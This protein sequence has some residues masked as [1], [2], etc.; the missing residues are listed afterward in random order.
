MNEAVHA[1]PP[2][3][4]APASVAAGTSTR[5]IARAAVRTR[6][7]E[8]AFELFRREGFDRVT[9]KEVSA[10]AGVSR[11]T[12]LRYFDSKEDAI[13]SAFE[14]LDDRV[15][16]VLRT[17]PADQDDWTALRH[18]MTTLLE[19]FRRAQR[20]F[21][22][23]ALLVETTPALSAGRREKQVGWSDALARALAERA[24]GS[25]SAAPPLQSLV[26]AAAAVEC[27]NIAVAQWARSDGRED[28]DQLLDEAFSALRVG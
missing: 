25:S 4:G 8:V 24:G 19:P 11:S 28:L 10:A 22:P 5:D 1:P 26:R 21:L 2:G 3:T 6:L 16:T 23:L 9:V 27:M 20:D 7:A 12:F 17:G 13:L 14:V 15:A 18:A